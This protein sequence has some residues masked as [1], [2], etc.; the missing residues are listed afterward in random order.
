MEILEGHFTLSP[1][2]PEY[3]FHSNTFR[4]YS[5]IRKAGLNKQRGT[6]AHL[7][8]RQGNTER[9]PSAFQLLP[10]HPPNP[11]PKISLSS[12]IMSTKHV[13][14]TQDSLLL[15]CTVWY[16]LLEK[17]DFECQF[18]L[19]ASTAACFNATY[20]QIHQSTT[21]QLLQLTITESTFDPF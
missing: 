4:N 16:P 8:V 7:P 5:N 19:A 18:H 15:L 20:L 14:K 9:F 3:N 21:N 6:H 2:F 11:T 1:S 10:N 17:A 13:W 12:I